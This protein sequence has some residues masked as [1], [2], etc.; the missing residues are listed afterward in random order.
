MDFVSRDQAWLPSPADYSPKSQAFSPSFS[1]RSRP[2]E[3]TQRDSGPGP[4]SYNLPSPTEKGHGAVTLK[5]RRRD[6]VDPH[7]PGPADYH[8]ERVGNDMRNISMGARRKLPQGQNSPGP[9]AYDLC[10]YRSE[11]KPVHISSYRPPGI[12]DRPVTEEQNSADIIPSLRGISKDHRIPIRF[13]GR[14]TT[15]KDD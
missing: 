1:M 4:S 15:H 8:T 12:A 7:Y 10:K 3:T 14:T 9:G 2:R 5:G 13:G 6:P 11:A